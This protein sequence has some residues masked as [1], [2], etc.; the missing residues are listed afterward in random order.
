[1]YGAYACMF[2]KSDR[3]YYEAV[4]VSRKKIEMRENLAR[5][6]TGPVANPR[7]SREEEPALA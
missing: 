1:M 3:G 4:G 2:W 5:I 7:Q 6:S